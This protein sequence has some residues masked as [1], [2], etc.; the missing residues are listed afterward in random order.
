M[1]VY[2][3]ITNLFPLLFHKPRPILL[4]WHPHPNIMQTACL[5]ACHQRIRLIQLHILFLLLQHQ[6]TFHISTL[7]MSHCPLP[8]RF[9]S[10]LVEWTTQLGNGCLLL[11]AL[12]VPMQLYLRVLVTSKIVAPLSVDIIASQPN[13]RC[14][15]RLMYLHPHSPLGFLVHSL[16]LLFLV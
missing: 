3:L 4:S 10:H 5:T 2:H 9:F 1:T 16:L 8:P 13:Y 11:H 15:Q 14:R 7:P 12:I 6:A